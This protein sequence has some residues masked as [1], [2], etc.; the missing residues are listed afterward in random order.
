VTREKFYA[1]VVTGKIPV[2]QLT[3][4]KLE[5]LMDR[6]AGKEWLPSAG[7]RHLDTPEA[8]R[9]DVLRGLKT[10]VAGGVEHARHF[11]VLYDKLPPARKVLD[12]AALKELR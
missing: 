7:L 6:Y 8:E 2:S 9:A 11:F 5:R 10:F 4:V 1:Q 3:P 12:P